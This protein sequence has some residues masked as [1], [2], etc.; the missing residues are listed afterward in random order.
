MNRRRLYYT[1]FGIVSL[2]FF[3]TIFLLQIYF[4]YGDVSP[5]SGRISEFKENINLIDKIYLDWW[6]SSIKKISSQGV[7]D[8]YELKNTYENLNIVISDSSILNDIILSEI[9]I[10][11]KP[12]E[13]YSYEVINSKDGKR[14][15]KIRLEELDDSSTNKITKVVNI[16]NRYNNTFYNVEID[17][18]EFRFNLS[19]DSDFIYLNFENYISNFYDNEFK[20]EGNYYSDSNENLIYNFGHINK[21][22]KIP[23]I[24]SLSAQIDDSTKN[25]FFKDNINFT[26]YNRFHTPVIT[27]SVNSSG[28]LK[29]LNTYSLSNVYE[30]ELKNQVFIFD[31]KDD[32]IFKIDKREDGSVDIINLIDN[33]K[34]YFDEN[35][36]KTYRVY[37]EEGGSSGVNFRMYRDM[38]V[39]SYVF[40]PN[41]TFDIYKFYDINENKF[42]SYDKLSNMF[43]LNSNPSNFILTPENNLFD[44]LNRVF[45]KKNKSKDKGYYYVGD[46]EF[47]N[48]D[49]FRFNDMASSTFKKVSYDEIKEEMVSSNYIQVM[50]KNKETGEFLNVDLNGGNAINGVLYNDSYLNGYFNY[51]KGMNDLSKFIFEIRPSNNEEFTTFNLYNKLIGTSVAAEYG[52]L[53]NKLVFDKTKDN[54]LRFVIEKNDGRDDEFKIKDDY[55]SYLSFKSSDDFAWVTSSGFMKRF[56]NI[57]DE[58]DV[59]EIYMIDFKES[60]NVNSG[61]YVSISSKGV[62][63]KYFLDKITVNN[64]QTESKSIDEYIVF[65]NKEFIFLEGDSLLEDMIAINSFRDVRGINISMVPTNNTEN[66]GY[67]FNILNGIY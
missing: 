41:K 47:Q 3:I 1:S 22:I 58:F 10:D 52:I 66:K 43:I 32:N 26:I 34:L 13:E 63:D 38:R 54:K 59:F 29:I 57:Q 23:I 53:D 55:G 51:E 17:S 6:D 36:M 9:I 30:S 60:N 46:N 67:R 35:L 12:L 45:M 7:K 42:L 31:S 65:R 16:Y 8:I 50:F 33:Y 15:F 18:F 19:K 25:L 20:I 24:S 2:V 61:D 4:K 27:F 62:D 21:N 39:G 48:G 14:I 44:I 5:V 11:R 37:E 28:D 40:T 56:F 64:K 49:I